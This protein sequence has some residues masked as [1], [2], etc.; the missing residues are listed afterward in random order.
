MNGASMHPVAPPPSADRLAVALFIALTLHAIIILGIS[1]SAEDRDPDSDLPTMEIT[2]VQTPSKPVEEADYLA[3]ASQEGAGNTTEKVRP[4]QESHASSPPP[5]S[6]S[7]PPQPVQRQ[8]LSTREAQ[9][10]APRPV[11][12]TQPEPRPVSAAELVDRSMEMLSLNRE[13]NQSLQ[14]YAQR[15]REKFISA[16]TREFKY[17]N[18]MNDWVSKVERVGELN[19]P[20]EARRRGLSGSLLVEVTLSADGHVRGVTILRPSGH[21]LL[22]DAAVRI[23]ELAAPY[24]PFPK[25]I[26]QETDVLHITR[27]WEFTSGHR[28]HGK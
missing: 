6:Q 20:D 5:P 11:E 15:P 7:E 2:I 22:D 25:R 14:A 9:Q 18:Y 12:R 13:I 21:K 1:F 23:V 27:T 24:A 8:L 4:Q 26:R 16:R 19:Y 10:A 3:A 28:L 17:A